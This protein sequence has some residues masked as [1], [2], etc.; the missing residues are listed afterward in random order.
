VDSCRIQADRSCC[1]ALAARA[2]SVT[3]APAG[4][5]WYALVAAALVAVGLVAFSPLGD[6]PRVGGL[7]GAMPPGEEVPGSGGAAVDPAGVH[8]LRSSTST[9]SPSSRARDG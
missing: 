9:R 2:V 4:H 3:R 1:R 7:L 8:E 5:P 6:E